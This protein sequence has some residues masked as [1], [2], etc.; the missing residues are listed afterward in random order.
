[1]P[2]EA[3]GIEIRDM[4]L[5]V[6]LLYLAPL[7]AAGFAAKTTASSKQ[8]N[9]ALLTFDLDD[10]LFPVAQVVEDAN[11]AMLQALWDAGYTHAT[12]DRIV[13][14]SKVIR[15]KQKK[16][17]TYTE[18]HK[19]A[20]QTEMELLSS[21]WLSTK[22][23]DSWLE[24]RHKSAERTLFTGAIEMLQEIKIKYPGA[25]IG[26]IT[27]GPGNPLSMTQTLA[28]YFDFCVSGEDEG[29]HPERKPH[30]GI[31]KA[32]LSKY[33]K[34]FPNRI[35]DTHV[36][37][38][39]GDCLANDV[40]G[41]SNMGAYTVW[42]E[43]EDL[44]DASQLPT[45]TKPTW[46]TKLADKARDRFRGEKITTLPELPTAIDNILHKAYKKSLSGVVGRKI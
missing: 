29:V 9:L 13:E 46:S 16:K 19:R 25:C 34:N 14:H 33:H 7:S 4:L 27:N 31:Y 28:P 18:L 23:Y 10:T 5:V 8:P 24:A 45:G 26:A 21:N 32:S 22:I 42:A 41:S 39:V 20:I 37:A 2:R 35:S 30:R 40:G 43:I 17:L 15:R 3:F 12:N 36:W 44:T 38:H 1:M 11:A 6:A